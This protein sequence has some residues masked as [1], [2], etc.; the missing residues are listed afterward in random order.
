MGVQ[1]AVAIVANIIYVPL[2]RYLV[3]ARIGFI[4]QII[5]VVVIAVPW[6]YNLY[7]AVFLG[8]L[9]NIGGN[10]Y[11]G[12][13]PYFN[14][15]ISPPKKR[16][17]IN[18]LV[19]A[20]SNAGGICGPLLAGVLYDMSPVHHAYP[21]YMSTA[22]AVIGAASC[23]GIDRGIKH[24]LD[25]LDKMRMAQRKAESSSK[26]LVSSPTTSSAAFSTVT[27]ADKSQQQ[28]SNFVAREA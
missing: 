20:M 2:T 15:V 9:V 17:L 26:S 4:G 13:L 16:G 21:F 6:I 14:A 8:M 3:P 18:S 22:M 25:L 7:A 24:A 23:F 10:L 28:P 1:A 12:G 5:C 11:F 19:I 27:A